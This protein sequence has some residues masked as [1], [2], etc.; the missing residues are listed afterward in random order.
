[1]Y[2][3]MNSV[4]IATATSKMIDKEIRMIAVD[5][6]EKDERHIAN[7][8]FGATARRFGDNFR[9]LPSVAA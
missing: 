7:Q 4:S 6:P 1:M 8:L 5:L 2:S 9:K 3:L